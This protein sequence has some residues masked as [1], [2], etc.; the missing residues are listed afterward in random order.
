MCH[1]DS[2]QNRPYKIPWPCQELNRGPTAPQ[3]NT[4]PVCHTTPYLEP[5]LAL[6]MSRTQRHLVCSSSIHWRTEGQAIHAVSS[7]TFW[8]SSRRPCSVYMGYVRPICEYTAPVWHSN[9]TV[10][11][12][13]QLQRIQNRA[14]RIILGSKYESYTETLSQHEL[15]TLEDRRLHFCYQFAQKC[16]ESELYNE[17]FPLNPKTHSMRMR[18]THKFHVRKCNTNR[19]RDSAFP[20]LTGLLNHI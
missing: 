13:T 1:P 10:D 2:E 15:H 20:F 16:I 19:Y 5:F 14:C 11:Q 3:T 17:W 6:S 12:S 8:S 18:N 4:L 9:I 7:K